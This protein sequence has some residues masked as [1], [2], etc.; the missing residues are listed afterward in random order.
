MRRVLLVTVAI[1]L[2]ALGISAA[3]AQTTAPANVGLVSYSLTNTSVGI[4]WTWT[5]STSGTYGFRFYTRQYD[6]DNTTYNQWTQ[7]FGLGALAPTSGTLFSKLTTDITG[8]PALTANTGYTWGVDAQQGTLARSSVSWSPLR[9]TRQNTPT[10]ITISGLSTDGFT[11]TAAD[12]VNPT[13]AIGTSKS[14]VRFEIYDGA[15]A[16]DSG[17]IDLTDSKSYTGLAA[18]T[19]YKLNVS[20][21][22]AENFQTAWYATTGDYANYV[23]VYTAALTPDFSLTGDTADDIT[24]DKAAGLLYNVGESFTFAANFGIDGAGSSY[25]YFWGDSV[26]GSTVWSD[27]D[28]GDLVLT[29]DAVGDYYLFVKALNGDGVETEFSQSG[30]YQVQA[31]PEPG[32]LLATLGLLGPA[33]MAFRRRR[34]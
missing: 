31:V 29:G 25:R 34:S 1:A 21:Y 33:V 18:N 23:S 13:A 20:A 5:G 24:A 7:V 32:T 26:D 10:D 2:L 9:Y 16:T 8:Y 11:A 14:G 3:F 30:L 22:N 15:T 28:T 12:I 4:R 17:K 19:Q 27:W 6:L